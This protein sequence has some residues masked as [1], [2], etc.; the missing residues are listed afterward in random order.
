MK[1]ILGLSVAALM[2]MGL[3][4]GGTWAYFSDTETSTNNVFSAGTIDLSL[5]GANSDVTVFTVGNMAPGATGNGNVSLRN[6]GSLPANLTVI[7]GT[8]A[9]AESTG[10]QGTAASGTTTT[11]V[12]TNLTGNDDDWIGYT[13][14]FTSGSNENAQVIVTDYDSTTYTLTFTPA[15]TAA[16]AT[17]TYNLH[18][19]Y[20]WD[21]TY[22]SAR[23][24][25]EL[26]DHLDISIWL[27]TNNDAVFDTGTDIVLESD[28]TFDATSLSSAPLSFYSGKTW[29]NCLSLASAAEATLRVSY[30]FA[31]SLDA[32]QNVAQGDSVTADFEFTLKNQ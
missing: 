25:G 15:V 7:V 8:V 10:Y 29:A 17:D 16:V 20:E 26:D 31:D 1:K 24:E 19:E 2:V 11:L 3:V 6:I 22:T 21:S 23:T 32:T 13:I 28:G 5:N 12:D 18:T 27:D 14:T 9:S 4:G 30:D